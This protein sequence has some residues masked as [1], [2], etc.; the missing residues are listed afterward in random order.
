MR[1]GLFSAWIFGTVL[2]APVA[3]A[4]RA[5][6]AL[7]VEPTPN[8][9][10]CMRGAA[11]EGAVEER[12][13]RR[14][15]VPPEQADLRVQI[16]YEKTGNAWRADL[17]LHNRAD[18]LLGRRELNTDAPH[19]SALDASVAL[20]VALLVDVAREQVVPAEVPPEPEVQPTPLQLPQDEYAPREPW[21]FEPAALGAIALGLLPNVAVGVTL[22]LGIEPPFF[23]LTELEAGLWRSSPARI[24]SA[25]SDFTLVSVGLFI[26]PVVL[27]VAPAEVAFCAGQHIG[28]VEVESFGF[29][30]NF[31]HVRMA[32]S[33][34]GRVQGGLPLGQHWRALAGLGAEAVLSRDQFYFTGPDDSRGELFRMAPAI[35]TIEAGLGVRF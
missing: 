3:A 21:H 29:E 8:T 4:E 26:C 20:V 9:E 35:L 7:D 15:F 10:Q 2:V 19:C 25:G 22:R 14:V 11:L 34:G 32:Y 13:A 23:W 12:L 24:D 1:L 6:A 28:R 33:L 27:K 17:T 18:E 16:R 30:Q 31:E 5:T